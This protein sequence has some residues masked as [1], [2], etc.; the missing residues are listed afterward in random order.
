MNTFGF[1]GGS[2]INGHCL[3]DDKRPQASHRLPCQST[4]FFI[5]RT[6]RDVLATGQDGNLNGLVDSRFGV[7]VHSEVVFAIIGNHVASMQRSGEDR[8]GT[9]CR[10][11]AESLFGNARPG[12][13]EV[14]RTQSAIR[15][16]GGIRSNRSIHDRLG[17]S[18]IT[19]HQDRRD[20]QH[21]AD[22]VET[23][24]DIVGWKIFGRIE[25]DSNQITNRVV[26]LD[27]I[28]SSHCHPTRVGFRVPVGIFKQGFDQCDKLIDFDRIRL[29]LFLGGHLPCFDHIKHIFPDA[30]S[31]D[32]RLGF[33]I[34]GQ[35]QIGFRLLF[36]MAG[37]AMLLDERYRFR[38]KSPG[39]RG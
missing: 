18:Q 31:T 24:S 15:W 22:V 38:G 30:T 10:N 39:E 2:S 28:E 3:D 35:I 23:M 13:F 34:C 26:V 17:R 1:V 9:V 27:S 36:A 6:T 14:S 32:Q 20:C 12:G 37:S 25:V 16:L 29:R 5:G 21:V 33:Q 7:T 4:R 11:R 8:I 19:L